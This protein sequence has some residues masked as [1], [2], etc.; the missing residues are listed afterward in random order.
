MVG[1]M[2]PLTSFIHGEWS[3]ATEESPALEVRAPATEELL[4]RAATAGLETVDRAVRDA[5]SAF[6]AWSVR[7]QG[8]RSRLLLKLADAVEDNADELGSLESLNVGKPSERSASELAFS[9]DCLRFFAGAARA[10]EGRAAGEYA[11]DRTS[12]IRRDPLGVVAGITPW[13]YPLMMAVWKLGPA[14]AVGNTVVLKP[15]ELTPLSTLRFAELAAEILPPGVLNVVTGDGATTGSALVHHPLVRM[16]SLTGDVDTGRKVAA[17]AASTLK[18]VH[19]E[20]GGKA[21]ALIFSDAD[22]DAAAARLTTSGFRNAGQ[23]CTAASRV[24]VA[25]E[26]ADDFLERFLP[27]VEAL[28][29]GDPALERVDVGPV[30]SANQR[31]RVMGF[32]RRACRSH[33]D[34]AVGG[35][36]VKGRGY[37]VSPTVVVGP[38]QDS[39][40]VQREVFGP[41]VTVQRFSDEAE[42]LAM[43]SDVVYGLTASVWSTDVRRCNRLVRALPY[44]TVWLN[45]HG[46]I[47][48]EMPH[49][50]A[51]ASGYGKDMSIYALEEYT[52]IKHVL[53][54]HV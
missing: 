26:V 5:A 27:M 45:D 32:V 50:G 43:A 18:R 3:R 22:L 35:H 51:R 6:D 23:D 13:N 1:T 38:A 15:S 40:I 34:I 37:F 42:A 8:E 28:R 10:L 41:V 20:L 21:P 12:S 25:D 46:K 4:G 7:S 47:T 36:A 54:S 33:A 53:S 49:G 9:A 30:I 14:A 52:L 19:L 24:L 11:P 29:V 44:G 31:D 48:P 16:V 2:T 17:A 39:E